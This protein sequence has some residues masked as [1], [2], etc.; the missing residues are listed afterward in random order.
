MTASDKQGFK[1]SQGSETSEMGP[2]PGAGKRRLWVGGTIGVVVL[3]GV[4]LALAPRLGNGSKGP[5]PK[6]KG[7]PVTL[8][9]VP[10]EVTRPSMAPMPLIIEFSGPLVAPRTAVVRAKATGTLLNLTV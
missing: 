3:A 2:Q 8:E 4:V 9:F 6:D 7:A 10:S 5:D 1:G